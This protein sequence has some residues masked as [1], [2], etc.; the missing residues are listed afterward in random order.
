[1]TRPPSTISVAEMTRLAHEHGALA[2]IDGAHTVGQIPLDL[3][4]LECDF[5]AFVGYKWLY[6]PYPSAALY[7]RREALDRCR[8][9][10]RCCDDYMPRLESAL[11]RRAH[12]G[13]G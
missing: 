11:L 1:M 3:R 10:S 8:C 5:Y 4:A 9:A 12:L 13:L 2:L 6:G 7:I